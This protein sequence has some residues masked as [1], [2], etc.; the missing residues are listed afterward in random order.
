MNRTRFAILGLILTTIMFSSC[1]SEGQRP[2]VEQVKIQKNEYG[3]NP[4][5]SFSS[6]DLYG[7]SSPKLRF[8]SVDNAEDQEREAMKKV[9]EKWKLDCLRDSGRSLYALDR[10]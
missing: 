6:K 4:T 9:S 2:D 3:F 10:R 8:T 7:A 5:V 1:M